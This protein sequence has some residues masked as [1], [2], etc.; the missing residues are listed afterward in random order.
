[1]ETQHSLTEQ[2][3]LLLAETYKI[4]LSNVFQGIRF[5]KSTV[6]LFSI[7]EGVMNLKAIQNYRKMKQ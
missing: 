4:F 6:I 3:K 2:T 1:M 7:D 5:L